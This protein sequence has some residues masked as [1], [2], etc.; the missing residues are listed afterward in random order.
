MGGTSFELLPT[1]TPSPMC[2]WCFLFPIV[3]TGN[4]AGPDIDLR[5]DGGIAQIGDVHGFEPAP[6]LV[7]FSSTK[8]PTC[9]FSA[10]Y[11]RLC[12]SHSMWFRSS[13][14]TGGSKSLIA[15]AISSVPRT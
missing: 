15:T 9:A 3:I 2:V 14:H 4:G 10:R 11:C 13:G 8:F 12:V 5:S 6:S 7:F 1:N